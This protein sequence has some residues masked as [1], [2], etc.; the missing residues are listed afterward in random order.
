MRPDFTK[1]EIVALYEANRYILMNRRA[2]ADPDAVHLVSAMRK[3]QKLA[4]KM[5]CAHCGERVASR[6]DRICNPCHEY[7][8]KMHRLPPNR[9]LQNRWERATNP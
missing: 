4:G 8:K 7:R 3:L 1:D 9:V 6:K 2:Q 5:M